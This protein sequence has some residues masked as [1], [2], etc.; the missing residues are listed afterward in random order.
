MLILILAIL[1]LVSSILA[2]L[3][4]LGWLVLLLIYKAPYVKTPAGAI[5][6]ILR[7]ISIK[8]EELVCDLGCGDAGVL[9]A[10]EKKYGCQ[11][12]GYEASPFT[13]IRALGNIRRN[14][15]KT[16]VYWRDFFKADLHKADIVFCFLIQSLMPRVGVYLHKQL[17]PGSQVVCYGYP[18]PQW[19]PKQVIDVIGTTS[20]IYIYQ[21]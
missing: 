2:F 19:H 17:K 15:A 8:P 13:Y 6:A 14:K 16:E 3:I 9:I 10:V 11:T 5:E 21:R 20:K 7:N 4:A 1:F 18:I 12:I